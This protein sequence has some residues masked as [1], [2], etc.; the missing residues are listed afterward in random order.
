MSGRTFSHRAIAA[1]VICLVSAFL[2][3]SAAAQSTQRSNGAHTPSG[4][5]PAA[6]AQPDIFSPSYV[7]L[8]S[9]PKPNAITAP[10]LVSMVDPQFPA[11]SPKGKF[12]GIAVV[13]TI[14]GT[15]GKPEQVHVVKSLGPE[16][17][18]N[19]VAAVEQYRFS[20]ALQHGKPVP[21]KVNVEVNFR[22]Y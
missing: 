8:N 2:C 21:V 18:K 19:A 5:A 7:P 14:V 15:D 4:T 20:P 6:K 9:K 12:F 11:D 13:A 1:G 22:R 16:F 10:R 3:A 17:D